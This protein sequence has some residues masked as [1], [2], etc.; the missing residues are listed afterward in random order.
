MDYIESMAITEKKRPLLSGALSAIL[1]LAIAGGLGALIYSIAVPA[2][3]ERFTEFY[4]LAPDR[5]TEN[6]PVELTVNQEASVIVG[7]INRE[8]QTT[9]YRVSVRINGLES[10]KWAPGDL[11][12]GLKLE[13]EI[14][15]RPETAGDNQEVEF[16]LFR[17]GQSEVYQ[18]LRLFIDVIPR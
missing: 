4:I 15:F 3:S 13:Q 7:L 2:T 8:Q 12:E 18:T 5:T 10:E 16:L 1:I 17:Q 14:S 11:A 6:Y 9:S